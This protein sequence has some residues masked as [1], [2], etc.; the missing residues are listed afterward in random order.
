MLLYYRKKR[1]E[2]ARVRTVQPI[3]PLSNAAWQT[4]IKNMGP[5][6]GYAIY[7]L[8]WPFFLLGTTVSLVRILLEVGSPGLISS[9]LGHSCSLFHPLLVGAVFNDLVTASSV[10]DVRGPLLYVI[11]AAAISPRTLLMDS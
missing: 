6:E 8:R 10:T 3:R 5:L 9:Q 11:S 2:L 4:P 7:H 1:F